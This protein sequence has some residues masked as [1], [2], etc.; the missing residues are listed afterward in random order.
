MAAP[1]IELAEL[2]DEVFDSYHFAM[3]TMQIHLRDEVQR[4]VV[5]RAAETGYENVEEYIEALLVAAC[6]DIEVTEDLEKLLLQRLDGEPGIE[7]T[8]EYRKQLIDE[9]DHGP[10]RSGSARESSST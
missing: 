2:S 1:Q 4:R 6:G 8:P 3:A 9:L 5:A 7:L 10:T